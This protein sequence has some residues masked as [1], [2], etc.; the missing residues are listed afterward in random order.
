MQDSDFLEI[1][2]NNFEYSIHFV[3]FAYN[4]A[5]QFIKCNFYTY[6]KHFY[7][8]KFLNAQM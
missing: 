1:F 5:A 3:K 7:M 8:I 6:F 4:L 2:N